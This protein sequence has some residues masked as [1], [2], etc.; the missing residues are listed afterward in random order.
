VLSTLHSRAYHLRIPSI[1][2]EQ[3]SDIARQANIQEEYIAWMVCLSAGKPQRMRQLIDTDDRDIFLTWLRQLT[4]LTQEHHSLAQCM[5]IYNT[6]LDTDY[7]DR[8]LDA[9]MM[10]SVDHHKFHIT[11]AVIHYRQHLSA[12]VHVENAK[13]ILAMTMQTTN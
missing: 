5:S 7:M 3:L 4:D 13:L 11:D 12:H 1:S 6:T 9:L 2:N 10:R 8:Y